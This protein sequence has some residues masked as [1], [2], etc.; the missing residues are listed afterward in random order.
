MTVLDPQQARRDSTRRLVRTLAITVVVV[1]AL[2]VSWACLR[3][4]YHEDDFALRSQGAGNPWFAPDYLFQK[5]GGHFMP[6]AFVVVQLVAKTTGLAYGVVALTLAAGQVLV[7]VLLYRLL[8]RHFGHRWP[9]LVPLALYCL[10]VPVLQAGIWWAA[11]LNMVP[12]LACMVIA[13]DH[14]LRLVRGGGRREIA[15]ILGSTVA[16]LAFYEKAVLLPLVVAAVL[17]GTTPGASG[18][19]SPAAVWR[20]HR[21]LVLGFVG[22]YVVWFAAYRSSATSDLVKLPDPSVAPSLVSGGLVG[23]WLPS[24]VGGPWGWDAAGSAY[25]VAR[26]GDSVGFILVGLLIALL[27]LAVGWGA[28]ARVMIGLVVLYAAAVLVILAVGRS[29]FLLITA[30]L[31]RYYADLTLVTAL[32]VA[33]ATMRLIDDP[34]PQLLREWRPPATAGKAVAA[35]VVVQGIVLAWTLAATSLALQLPDAAAKSWTTAAVASLRSDESAS[36]L[37]DGTVPADVLPPLFVPYTSYGWFFS[38]VPGLPSFGE[39]TDDLRTF[40]D[41]G[42][43][44]EAHVQGPSSL[45]GPAPNCGR[46][47]TSE[48]AFVPMENQIIDFAHTMKISYLAAEAT[49]LEV[50]MGTGPTVT[51][52]VRKGFADV[53][54]SFVGGGTSVSLRATSPGVVVCVSDVTIGAVAPGPAP[55]RTQ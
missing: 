53:Y 34:A 25:S 39:S 24:L 9:I 51:V 11:A 36:P 6:A 30:A 52:P 55:A 4:W 33:L 43:L 50:Q 16:A 48:G 45:P 8:V 15:W 20:R 17:L 26:P 23:T 18:R 12:F 2:V 47:V 5:W 44:V 42:R 22:I 21:S 1:H 13:V 19:I 29:D 35:L 37:L 28:R 32:A 27:A 46:V 38:G 10:S 14:A 41:D 49:G 40:R 3:G 7:S 31:P 54:L